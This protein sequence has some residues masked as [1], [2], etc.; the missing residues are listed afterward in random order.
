MS[1]LSIVMMMLSKLISILA[2]CTICNAAPPG[3]AWPLGGC[4]SV[5]D[6]KHMANVPRDSGGHPTLSNSLY[7][8]D[9]VDLRAVAQ[10]AQTHGKNTL[11]TIFRM[12]IRN[13]IN[14]LCTEVEG[15]RRMRL[16]MAGLSTGVVWAVKNTPGCDDASQ[17][18]REQMTTLL[19]RPAVTIVRVDTS[20]T[21]R[22]RL[23]DC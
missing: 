4:P 7:F 2:F 5:E 22:E 11:V 6:L 8:E 12:D 9:N 14:E 21:E 13:Y 19:R 16:A 17:A 1:T 20:G 23:T 15:V 18:F 3:L 10:I